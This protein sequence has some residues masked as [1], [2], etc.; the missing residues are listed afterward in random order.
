VSSPK[1]SASNGR[2]VLKGEGISLGC[3][4]LTDPTLR[5][6]GSRWLGWPEYALGR[7]DTSHSV[8]SNQPEQSIQTNY[9]KET[10]ESFKSL[11]SSG[12]AWLGHCRL[13]WGLA[14]DRT[15]EYNDGLKTLWY[16]R[17]TA[18][19]LEAFHVHAI[20]SAL[21]QLTRSLRLLTHIRHL[22]LKPP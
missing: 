6:L 18:V 11:I 7:Q 4:V 10:Y 16:T 19:S 5:A 21:T 1:G 20:D 17:L 15:S 22:P 3:A 12:M 13:R 9:S 8:E 2:E 14:C